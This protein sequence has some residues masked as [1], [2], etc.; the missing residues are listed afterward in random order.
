MRRSNFV[1]F[2]PR[3]I[4]LSREGCFKKRRRLLR[5]SS[6]S[7]P[8]AR[9]LCL[10]IGDSAGGPPHY[11]HTAMNFSPCTFFYVAILLPALW[12]AAT[13]QYI[14]HPFDEDQKLAY[15]I[16]GFLIINLSRIE[17]A[18]LRGV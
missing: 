11:S 4:L 5:D 6:K 2:S 13:M 7:F 12:L 16:K 1:G 14:N 8:L 15:Y 10:L 9:R 17:K 3:D 18:L